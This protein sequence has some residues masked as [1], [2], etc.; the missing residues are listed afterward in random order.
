MPDA[1]YKVELTYDELV[2]LDGR[3]SPDVQK[4]IELA[5]TER[6]YGFEFPLINE[7]IRKSVE[8]GVFN[9]R[10][11]SA[12]YCTYCTKAAGYVPYTR[13]SYRHRKGEPNRNKPRYFPAISFFPG[14]I[15]VVGFAD[16][17]AEC[18]EKHQV[19]QSVKNY[20]LAHDLPVE[21][22][23]DKATK[24]IKDPI[25]ICFKCEKEMQESKMGR[26]EALM[27]GTYPGRCPYCQA[28]QELF[29]S[30][31]KLTDKYVMVR[32]KEK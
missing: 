13:S 16:I 12:R 15:H 22:K 14:F 18:E 4:I 8:K 3:V 11:E 26:V 25:R 20:L 27:G 9:W 17:C 28:S 29:G 30:T 5:K 6:G 24:F 31:H 23:G 32:V 21:L 2:V 19:I 1:K 7:L 10:R